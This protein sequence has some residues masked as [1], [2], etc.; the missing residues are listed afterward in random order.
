[1]PRKKISEYRAKHIVNTTLKTPYHGWVI[2]AENHRANKYGSTARFVIKVDQAIKQRFKRGLIHLN[3]TKNNLPSKIKDLTDKGYRYLVI[4]PYHPHSGEVERYLNLRRERG[5]VVFSYSQSGGVDI[6]ANAET[7]VSDYFEN[8][9]IKEL[10]TKTGL[11]EENLL[12]L[13]QAFDDNYLSLLE[14][15]P[16]VIEDGE[17]KVL[18]AAI[19]VDSSAELLVDTWSTE[20]FRTPAT[21]LTDEEL[22]V[23]K[24]ASD[25]PA[26]FSLEVINP[27]GAIFLLLSGG[28]ASVVVADEIFN[29]GKGDLLANYGEYSG[30]PNEEETR[31]YTEQV[32]QL[33]LK[34][35]AKKKV[36]LIGGAVANFTDIV[37]TFSGIISVIRAHR[38]Q[39]AQQGVKFYVRRGGPRQEEGLRLI[40]EVLQEANVFGGVYAPS[41][42]IPVAVKEIVESINEN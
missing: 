23:R 4:E 18:D 12:S 25:S 10:A 21:T 28:G 20:D 26:S 34:S 31:I 11:T 6:E 33:L 24:L 8:F 14:V 35:K 42:S 5:G 17:V 13:R 27:N 19:E 22:V 37:N 40:S 15:N 29:L 41:T 36:V 32:V 9:N 16:Y 1:M 30:N 3:I 2:D 38:I 39:L 7:I